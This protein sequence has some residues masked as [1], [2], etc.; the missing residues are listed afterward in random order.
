V[1]DDI[2]ITYLD[3]GAVLAKQKQYA[4]A[5]TA[6]RR[7]VELDPAQPNAHFRLGRVYQAMGNEAESRKEFAK[8]RELHEKADESLASKMSAVPPPLPQ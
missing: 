3:L 5:A 2:R 1:K 4:D 7:A 6:L 8:V